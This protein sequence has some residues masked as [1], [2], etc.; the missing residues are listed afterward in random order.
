MCLGIPMRIRA[1][2]GLMARCEAKGSE[3]EVNLLMLEQEGLA[4]GDFVVVHLGYAVDRVTEE[5][6]AAAWDVYDQMLAAEAA[7]GQRGP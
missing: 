6:A 5:E 3:R 4:V 2:D 1:I 7:S